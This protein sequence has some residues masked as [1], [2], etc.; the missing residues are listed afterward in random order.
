MQSRNTTRRRLP[1]LVAIACLGGVVVAGGPFEISE[2]TLDGG[3][4]QSTGGPFVVDGTL[5]QP[6]A[7]PPMSGGGFEVVGGFWGAVS[8]P[9]DLDGNGAI[10]LGDLNIVLGSFGGGISGDINGDGV[11]D[12]ADLN[13][14]LGG[15]GS[16]C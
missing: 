6:D 5:G 7:S 4:G 1:A 13:L 9:A 11:T 2:W 3:G 12:L 16:P 14:V 10:D 15:C 8:C